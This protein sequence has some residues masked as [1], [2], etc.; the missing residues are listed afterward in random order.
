MK[1]TVK[2]VKI[3]QFASEETLCFEASVYLD[4][5]KA[6]VA[7]NDGRGGCNSYYG[8]TAKIQEAEL[9]AATQTCQW[10][11]SDLDIEVAKAIDNFEI[12]KKLK[13]L[14]R[15]GVAIWDDGSNDSERGIFRWKCAEP[16]RSALKARIT[17]GTPHVVFL[18]EVPFDEAVELMRL[19]G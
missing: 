14:L 7:S 9:W 3:A 5:K 12:Q 2:N 4:G 11:A 1:I 8:N 6:F 18:D 15:G 10:G 13:T 17:E 16:Q 19:A